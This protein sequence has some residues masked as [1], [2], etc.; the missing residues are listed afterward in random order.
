MGVLGVYPGDTVGA[1][2][3]SGAP[4]CGKRIWISQK[5]KESKGINWIR[6]RMA[7]SSLFISQA[8]GASEGEK[9]QMRIGSWIRRYGTV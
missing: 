1:T 8:R 7:R 9:Y 2:L 4:T 6:T 3:D 5:K